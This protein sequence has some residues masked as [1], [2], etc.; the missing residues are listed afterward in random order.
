MMICKADFEELFPH[1]F[2]PEP[3]PAAPQ[4][5][6]PASSECIA[7]R[8]DD[9]GPSLPAGRLGRTAHGRRSQRGSG[10]PAVARPGTMPA[11]EAYAAA[12]T[13]LSAYGKMTTDPH[14]TI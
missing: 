11:A 14:K 2:K 7:R 9:S 1:L 5:A 12:W 8:E 13:M 6:K 3:A 10:M 4:M